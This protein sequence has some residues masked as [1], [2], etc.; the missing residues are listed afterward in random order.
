MKI[1]TIEDV[2]KVQLEILEYFKEKCV[3]NN[4]RYYL[5]YGT[6]LGAVRH[7]GYIPWDD[8]ID[9]VMPRTD[10]EGFLKLMSTDNHS[11]IKIVHLDNC[12]YFLGPYAMLINTNTGMTHD[13]VRQEYINDLGVYIDIFPL[14]GR[15]ESEEL[16]KMLREH[17]WL[18]KLDS[19]LIY[20]NPGSSNKLKALQKKICIPVLRLF[21]Q[22]RICKKIEILSMKYEYDKSKLI[23]EPWG[24]E[25]RWIVKKAWFEKGIDISFEGIEFCAPEK[26]KKCLEKWYGNYMELPPVEERKLTH[27]YTFFWKD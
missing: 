12:Q 22:K 21:G 24:P 7:K 13:M 11:Y 5:A 9:V 4:L 8:D 14:D 19:L 3:E 25:S 16:S 2:R 1:L 26:Y 18:K 10:Y 6:L 23:G 17:L 15:P 20:K 27:G